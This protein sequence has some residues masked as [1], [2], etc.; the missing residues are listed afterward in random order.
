VWGASFSPD[1]RRIVTASD[2]TTARVWDAE[3]GR[4]IA[5][6]QAYEGTVRSASF[7]PDGLRIVTAS[8]D[9]TARVWDAAS[10]AEIALL[11]G[12]D[13]MVNGASYSRDGRRIVT[14]SDDTTARVW[15]AASAQ[16]IVVLRAHSERVLSASFSPDGRRI[17]TAS[18]DRTA[19]VWDVSRTATILL[20][21]AV[22]LTAALAQGSGRPTETDRRDLLMREA[23]ADLFVAAMG[24]LGDRSG[25]LAEA[26]AALH[27][28]LHPNCYLSS[29][30]FAAKFG[31]IPLKTR[32][33]KWY[34]SLWSRGLRRVLAALLLVLALLVLALLVLATRSR[35]W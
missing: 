17:V 2:D 33:R 21:R 28:Q 34:W 14:A 8:S 9:K 24:L 16:E 4:E 22:I 12:H 3:S 5:R 29:T 35:A 19:R 11:R 15:D 13:A 1:G 18:F 25:V 23:P 6:L 30:E 26:V 20:E 32:G 31:L 27:A 7:S 10:G